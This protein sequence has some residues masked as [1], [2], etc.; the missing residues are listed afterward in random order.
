MEDF[1]GVFIVQ[2]IGVAGSIL[3]KA[4]LSLLRVF[5]I[6]EGD[7]KMAASTPIAVA[8]PEQMA[9]ARTVLLAEARSAHR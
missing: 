6:I 9:I 7:K 3:I 5:K 2:A 4:A 8:D 1:S